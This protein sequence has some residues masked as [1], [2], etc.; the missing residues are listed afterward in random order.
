MCTEDLD[1]NQCLPVFAVSNYK[2]NFLPIIYILD[3]ISVIFHKGLHAQKP[4]LSL[5]LQVRG[6]FGHNLLPSSVQKPSEVLFCVL[7]EELRPAQPPGLTY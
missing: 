1:Q 4:D 2:T 7:S 6:H 5:S 3:G